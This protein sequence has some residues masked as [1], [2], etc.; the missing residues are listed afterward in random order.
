MPSNQQS[1]SSSSSSSSPEQQQQL[2]QQETPGT[3]GASNSRS[4]NSSSNITNH[5]DN[6]QKY[7]QFTTDC[8]REHAASLHCISE[9]YNDKNRNIA[10]A[11]QFQAYKECRKEERLRRL[12]ANSKKDSFWGFWG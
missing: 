6:D 2:L 12:E 10:C 9:N 11:S 1:A 7:T 3:S 4:S 8:H 5:K